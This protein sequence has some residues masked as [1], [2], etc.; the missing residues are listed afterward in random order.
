MAL[1]GLRRFGRVGTLDRIGGALRGVRVVGESSAGGERVLDEATATV[2][3]EAFVA[4]AAIGPR[5]ADRSM[6]HDA[7]AGDLHAKIADEGE[8]IEHRSRQ[9]RPHRVGVRGDDRVAR[10]ERGV[11][12]D[13]EAR[14]AEQSQGGCADPVAECSAGDEFELRQAM[15]GTIEEED[16]AADRPRP[17]RARGAAPAAARTGCLLAPRDVDQDFAAA[18]M[19]PDPRRTRSRLVEPQVDFAQCGLDREPE[20]VRGVRN[21]KRF[22]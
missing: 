21:T 19:R 3:V 20:V 11:I 9:Q 14:H 7:V 15:V 1:E 18:F 5:R 4:I 16:R 6:R 8:G 22:E 13:L 10:R 2:V 17:R 12:I